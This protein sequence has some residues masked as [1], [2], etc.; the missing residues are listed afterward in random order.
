M[1]PPSLPPCEG[2]RKAACYDVV[3]DGHNPLQEVALDGLDPH[4]VAYDRAVE[5]SPDLDRFCCSSAVVEAARLGLQ[6][7][8]TPCVE[9][10]GTGYLAFVERRASLGLELRFERLWEP[11]EAMW[12]LVCPIV[13]PDVDALGDTL[14]EKI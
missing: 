14:R 6:P 1:G 13:G 12:G 7:G 2:T 3:V 9:R 10:A 4:R 8:R 11:F 5:L